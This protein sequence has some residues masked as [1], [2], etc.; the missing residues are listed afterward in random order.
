MDDHQLVVSGINAR[1]LLNNPTFAF[2]V[3][4]LESQIKVQTFK[5]KFDDYQARQNLYMLWKALESLCNILEASA[6]L[7]ETVEPEQSGIASTVDPEET[8]L[9]TNPIED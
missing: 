2:V 4:D 7:V 5:T 1:E 3:N 8:D 9:S 6:Q